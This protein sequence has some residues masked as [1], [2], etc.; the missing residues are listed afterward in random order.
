MK[1]MIG[2]MAATTMFSLG[3]A[4][5]ALN[6]GW[7]RRSLNPGRPVAITGQ[8]YLRV[9]LGEYTPV[10]AEALVLENGRDAAIFVSADMVSLRG[11]ILDM[12]C[13]KIRDKAPEDVKIPCEEC[14]QMITPAFSMS[15]TQ[16]AAYTKKKYGK[17]LCAECAKAKKEEKTDGAE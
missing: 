13:A 12:A 4:E 15:V 17:H 11:G 7:G 1:R 10:V 2:I 16:L 6:I 3:A 8:F 14:G 5:P 9:S